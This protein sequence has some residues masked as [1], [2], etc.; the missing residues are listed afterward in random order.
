M[1][2]NYIAVYTAVF[3]SLVSSCKKSDNENK[4]DNDG[5]VEQSVTKAGDPY[6]WPEYYPGISYDFTSEYPQLSPPTKVLD[7]CPSVVGTQTGTWWSFRWGSRANPLVTEKAITP[8]L[9]YFDSEFSYF[10]DVMGWPAD[11]RARNGYYSSVYLYGSGLCT[12]DA[13]SDALGGWQS[14]VNYQGESWPLVLASYYPVYSFDPSCPYP[15]AA[16]QQSAMIHEGIH[17]LLA[18]Y[19]GMKNAAWFQEGGNVWFQQTAD[20]ARNGNYSSLGWLGAG[21]VI[22]PFIPIECYSGWLLDGSFG[23]PSAEGVNLFDGNQ[24]ICTWRNLLGGKQYSSVFPTYLGVVLGNKSVPWLWRFAKS[25]VLEGLADGLGESTT[26]RLITEYH[27]RQASVDFGEW[28]GAITGLLDGAFGTSIQQEWQPAWHDVDPW[29]ATPYVKTT[30]KDNELTP[31]TLTLPGWS[32]ANL[33]PLT[34]ADTA[35]RVI[36]NFNP[37]GKNMTCQLVYRSTKDNAVYSQFVSK[38]ECNLRLYERPANSVVIAVITNNDFLYIGEETRKAK[39][40]YRLQ[41][42]SGINGTA[43]INTRWYQWNSLQS[44]GNNIQAYLPKGIDWSQYCK[45]PASPVNL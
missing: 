42:T 24:Q 32:G 26:R 36:V 22:A 45:Y 4:T 6:T 1:F 21:D 10:R 35:T 17:A 44:A 40:D 28:S 20:A 15:D 29:I 33:I 8:L 5:D 7:D 14:A 27:A 41:L 23:G 3:L 9:A 19:E 12:D 2:T 34:V 13:P 31:D 39:Y 43:S 16:S 30:N 11:K 38:G 37:I 18:D 25:R